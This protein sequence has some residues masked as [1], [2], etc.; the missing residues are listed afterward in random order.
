MQTKM[1]EGV[2]REGVPRILERERLRSTAESGRWLH[3]RMEI[4]KRRRRRESYRQGG[5]L[6]ERNERIKG[7]ETSKDCFL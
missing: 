1:G 5:I 3:I 6:T 4:S 2:Q 7:N